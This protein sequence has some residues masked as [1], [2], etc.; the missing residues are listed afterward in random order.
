VSYLSARF[1][2]PF[3]TLCAATLVLG[4][5]TGKVLSLGTNK[6]QSQEVAPSQVSGPVGA[7]GSGAAHPNVCCSAG[8]NQSG[9]CVVYPDAPF[10][11][12]GS[13]ATTYPD[14]RSCCPLDGSGNCSS[15]PPVDDAGPPSGG[16]G[17]GSCAYA[18]PPGWYTPPN[19]TG[20]ECCQTDS[21]GNTLCAGS[22]GGAPGSCGSGCTCTACTDDSGPCPPCNCPPPT[23]CPSP[24]V[25]G[26]CPPGWQNPQ[27]QPDLCCTTDASGTIECFSQAGPPGPPPVG[28]DAGPGPTPTACS[29]SGSTD[30]ALGPCG[31]Q[32]QT[33]GH[34][35]AVNCD[36]GTNVCACTVDNGAPTTTFADNGNTCGDSKALFTSCGFP[37]Q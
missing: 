32:E 19:A 3:G 11:Q 10:T 26:T 15:P 35:Y 6:T 18:C 4:A 16:S 17:G 28:I 27:G 23:P 12:C 37:A 1:V 8:P 21:S 29:G 24:P 22:A 25:C 2:A 20:N 33:G 36:P 34:T 13:G 30:G 5:C 31:C 7:C 14:P 9:T